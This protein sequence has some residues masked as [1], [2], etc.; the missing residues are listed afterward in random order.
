MTASL[1]FLVGALTIAILLN[2]TVHQAQS[3]LRRYTDK[4]RE[5]REIKRAKAHEA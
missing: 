3:R 4:Q 1:I 5:L 2:A